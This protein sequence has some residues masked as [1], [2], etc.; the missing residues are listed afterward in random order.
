M[1]AKIRDHGTDVFLPIVAGETLFGQLSESVERG[2]PEVSVRCRPN[3]NLRSVVE[4]IEALGLEQFS[5]LKW[6]ESAKLEM[7][8]I[9]VGLNVF[10]IIALFIAAIGITNTLVTTVLERTREIGIFKALG[11]KDSEVTAVFLAEG[12]AV[13][14]IGGVLGVIIARLIAIPADSLVFE[15]VKKVSQQQMISTS[16]FEFPWWLSIGSM[17][18]ALF[19]TTAAAWYPARRAARIDPVEALRHE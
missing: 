11:A 7:T 8:L 16:V 10:S 19:V 4:G 3:G 5:T 13:G 2:F 17:M 9:S 12:M 15:L 14:L 1:P 18:F 6:Y